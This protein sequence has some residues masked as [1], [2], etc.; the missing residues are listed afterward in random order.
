MQHILSVFFLLAVTS[1]SVVARAQ[2]IIGTPD[3]LIGKFG[4]TRQQCQSYHRKSDEIR[5]FTKNSYSACGG[6]LCQSDVVSHRKI[7]NVFR[8]KLTNFVNSKVWVTDIRQ[9]DPDI[10]ELIGGG[11]G[12]KNEVI[13]KCNVKDAIAGIGRPSQDFVYFKKQVVCIM[14]FFMLS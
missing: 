5:I 6:V 8:L 14:D 4:A 1:A 11:I 9:L 3:E 7:G 2:E 12:G 13:V 10:F